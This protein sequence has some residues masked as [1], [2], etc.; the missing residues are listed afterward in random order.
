[1]RSRRIKLVR[2]VLAGGAAGALLSVIPAAAMAAAPAAQAATAPTK[3]PYTFTNSDG[4]TTVI[5]SE[6]K[7]VVGVNFSLDAITALGVHP[8]GVEAGTSLPPY[9]NGGESDGIQFI[10]S[11][12]DG[13]PL[14]Y[15]AI[16][17]LH[18]D[19]IIAG[20]TANVQQLDQIAPTVAYP[21]ASYTAT[22]NPY[23]KQLFWE[24]AVTQL[25]PIFNATA[26]AQALIARFHQRAS[27]MIPFTQGSTVAQVDQISAST[28]YVIGRF[29]ILASMGATVETTVAGGTDKSSENISIS[30]ELLPNIT[31]QKDLVLFQVPTL[32]EAEFRALPLYSQIPAVQTNQLYF[33]YW[34]NA[35]GPTGNADE[36]TEWSEQMF[37][38]TPLEATLA[39][40]GKQASTHTGV[41]DI[42]VSKAQSK[43]CWNVTTSGSIGKPTSMVIQDAKGKVFVTLGKGFHDTGCVSLKP[44]TANTLAFS[45]TKYTVAVRRTSVKHKRVHKRRKTVTTTSTLLKG[46]LSVQSPAFFGNGKDTLYT[47]PPNP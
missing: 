33:T 43:A 31:A 36:L 13:S 11:P 45:P 46:S 42:D 15:E 22:S 37:G 3:F 30:P 47:P 32:D 44:A 4:S 20:N 18:P 16:A 41:A 29:P 17:A 10:P 26:R 5:P 14:N 8:V 6:P 23:P 21:P 2:L 19:L 39:G 28:I 7:R 38:V 35:N 27:T 34:S 25:A 12:T 9:M 24:N 40:L 1:M